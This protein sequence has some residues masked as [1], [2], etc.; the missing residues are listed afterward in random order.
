MK[1][2][3]LSLLTI[4]TCF[5]VNAQFK[6]GTAYSLSIPQEEMGDN[7]HPVHSLNVSGLYSIKGL[8]N[9][10]QVGAE[11]G[12]G[13]YAYVSKEQ[14]LRF[15]DGSGINT[16]VIYAS[17]VFNA[18]LVMRANLLGKGKAIPYINAKGG[19]SNFFSNITVGDPDDF[20]SCRPLERKNIIKDNTLFAAYGGG[21]QLDMTLFAKKEKAGKYLIDISINKIRGGK[22]NYINT[23][24]IQS[25]VETDPNNPTPPTTGKGEP[26]NIQFINITTSTI[27]EH[28]IAE[29]YNSPLRMIDIRLGIIFKLD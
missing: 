3:Y 10:L 14:D 9:R 11:L 16:D 19:V 1:K 15:S 4:F 27:H 18:A 24:D 17:N 26:L 7:I 23:K 21:V 12:V 22:L 28:Q 20:S 2:I 8:C 5:I 25:H 29:L 6:F 13:N